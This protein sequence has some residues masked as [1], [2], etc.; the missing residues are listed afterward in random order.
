MPSFFSVRLPSPATGGAIT[1]ISSCEHAPLIAV[2]RANCILEIYNEEAMLV[3]EPLKLPAAATMMEWKPPFPITQT[4]N[5]SG[6]SAY[7]GLSSSAT[8][9]AAAQSSTG[10]GGALFIG[11]STGMVTLLSFKSATPAL[12]TS[13]SSTSLSSIVPGNASASLSSTSATATPPVSYSLVA[14]RTDVPAGQPHMGAISLLR[15][16]PEGSRVVTGDRAGTIAVWRIDVSTGR[17][18]TVC[19]IKKSGTPTRLAFVT[20]PGSLMPGGGASTSSSSSTSTNGSKSSLASS[21]PPVTILTAQQ[22]TQL[23]ASVPPFGQSPFSFF[24][25]TEAG[26]VSF[27]DDSGRSLDVLSNLHSPVEILEYASPLSSSSSS[28]SLPFEPSRLVVIT[29]S[30]LMAHIGVFPDGSLTALS[31]AKVSIK[32]GASSKL[33]CMAW[34]GVL[35]TASME[36]PFVRCWDTLKEETYNLSLSS[37]AVGGLRATAAAQAQVKN[38]RLQALSFS[39]SSGLLAAGTDT[40]HMYI[41]RQHRHS[42]SS[43]S[44]AASQTAS[45]SGGLWEPVAAI[46]LPGA[47]EGMSWGSRGSTVGVRL[48]SEDVLVVVQASMRTKLVPPLSI[49]QT[50][51]REVVIEN[52]EPPGGAGKDGAAAL[53]IGGPKTKST[54]MLIQLSQSSGSI[55][56]ID[57]THKHV[58]LW[59]GRAAEVYA[60]ADEKTLAKLTLSQSKQSTSSSSES[61]NS[62]TSV[63]PPPVLPVL[64]SFKCTS[65]EMAISGDQ[66]FSCIPDDFS[67]SVLSLQGVVKQSILFPEHDGAPC[68]LDS[69]GKVL[70]V[71]TTLGRVRVYDTS[72]LEPRL[73]SSGCFPAPSGP[74]SSTSS[75]KLERALINKGGG[76]AAAVAAAAIGA[77]PSNAST[78]PLLI[79]RLKVNAD[80]S[81]LALLLGPYIGPPL[82][83]PPPPAAQL[84]K[85]SLSEK[86]AAAAA[87]EATNNSYAAARLDIERQQYCVHLYS[88]DNDRWSKIDLQRPSSSSSSSSS[89]ATS[90][91]I[92][93]SRMPTELTWDSSDPR[94][95]AVQMTK[96]RGIAS[97]TGTIASIS[98]SDDGGSGGDRKRVID[99]AQSAQSSVDNS[100]LSEGKS[101]ADIN[102]DIALKSSPSIG[103]EKTDENEDGE[104]GG[105]SNPND[106]VNIE[107]VTLF[108]SDSIGGSALHTGSKDSS[109]ADGT[110]NGTSNSANLI[111]QD[112]FP[113]HPPADS[114]LG[115]SA[116]F[117]LSSVAESSS[118]GAQASRV[119][120]TVL[121]DFFGLGGTDTPGS[122]SSPLLDLETKKALLDF[123]YFMASGNMDEAYRSVK[124]LLDSSNTSGGGGAGGAGGGGLSLWRN[125]AQMTVK[126]G[127]LDVAKICLGQ[128]SLARSARAVRVLGSEPEPEANIAVVAAQ[129]GMLTDAQRLLQSAERPDLQVQLHVDSG[130]WA[131]ALSLARRQHRIGSRGTRFKLARVLESGGE[132]DA[133]AQQYVL[134]GADT[135]VKEV[136][137]M[138]HD[139]NMLISLQKF[140]DER[141]NDAPLN[142]AYGKYLFANPQNLFNVAG[143]G[144][145]SST[146]LGSG[147]AVYFKRAN[148]I[149]SLVRIACLSGDLAAAADLVDQAE[150]VSNELQRNASSET[151]TSARA[152]AELALREGGASD[153]SEST[154][155]SPLKRASSIATTNNSEAAVQ[156]ALSAYTSAAYVLARKF[157]EVGRIAEAL[158]FFERSG[159]L[160]HA[161]RLARGNAGSEAELLGLALRADKVTQMDVA[162]LLESRNSF[163]KAAQL[164]HSAGASDQALRL[165]FANGLFNEMKSIADDLSANEKAPPSL[166]IDCANFF[167]AKGQFEKGAQLLI[168]GGRHSEAIDLCLK[169]KVIIT[170]TMADA[171]TPS[172]PDETPNASSSSRN[173]E[174]DKERR[175]ALLTKLAQACK[176]QGSY[177]L[178]TKKFTQAGDKERALKCLVLSGDTDKVIYYAQV[179]RSK[180]IYIL[181][182]NYLQTLN[183]SAEPSIL[184]AILECYN[185]AKAYVE[186]CGFYE[187]CASVEVD[188]FR[189]YEKALAALRESSKAATKI[190]DEAVKQTRLLQ[191]QDKVSLV[192]RFVSAR[193]MA[194]SDP[195]EMVNICNQLVEQ[196]DCET[197]VRVG[198]V[199]ALLVYFY[200]QRKDWQNA[201]QSLER[202]R[203]HS[204]ALEPFIDVP[205]IETAYSQVGLDAR[206]VGALTTSGQNEGDGEGGIEEELEGEGKR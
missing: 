171:M 109:L 185:K 38:Q 197:A 95:L 128:L 9:T 84:G 96:I 7:N 6:N 154:P 55:K 93:N 91:T 141:P 56:G 176:K 133:A 184:M 40:G 54:S 179:C 101:E 127:R 164:Y 28:S 63:Q 26:V 21:A 36:E 3:C 196:H 114:L 182:A 130:K 201:Y 65:T 94:F 41:W 132:Y 161:V 115:L 79:Q 47:P 186:L 202:M 31:R 33:S 152:A 195:A 39:S 98:S 118:S 138:F 30:L 8:N 136:I 117:I 205:L 107:L 60:I 34:N 194:K 139:A 198:D 188:E 126:S 12:S 143:L 16:S 42:S 162:R 88:C 122:S 75:S 137:R 204:I 180:E 72:R 86:M 45:S 44:A 120:V 183:W 108:A 199:F 102:D 151:Y 111:V 61:A 22:Q 192:E 189:N 146:G 58:L 103:S 150:I 140:V 134:C 25:A 174:A 97:N 168:Q 52:R 59:T 1:A 173:T 175:T 51:N 19:T 83:A 4:S 14:K 124:L 163:D 74:L 110:T 50:S 153:N 177:H 172:K 167:V 70:A 27:G 80:G 73:L 178:A 166:F 85:M 11:L 77:P 142:A 165:C 66:I 89:S 116:P 17:A 119:K 13:S 158:R 105:S 148:D 123:S 62:S 190:Q 147:A 156:K 15:F 159:R 155:R 48:S 81:R 87:I 82:L 193:K 169:E 187:A 160:S 18:H 78:T 49:V 145:T 135:H 131:S 5:S 46:G 106:D 71:C 113:M 43:L 157:E 37:H 53:L 100:S 181:A 200:A 32:G 20:Y 92:N 149:E 29:K 170:E 10:A 76:D 69:N 68:K 24:F 203:A 64:S 67:V 104:Q 125:M 144:V 112:R 2:T 129:L 35:C 191:L 57:A 121:R 23:I 206:A 99:D 90:S